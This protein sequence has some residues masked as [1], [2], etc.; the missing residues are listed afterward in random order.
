[1]AYS[2]TSLEL[3]EMGYMNVGDVSFFLGGEK[4]SFPEGMLSS[5]SWRRESKCKQQRAWAIL[6]SMANKIRYK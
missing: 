3:G 4:T 5:I 6:K 1:M 2:Y